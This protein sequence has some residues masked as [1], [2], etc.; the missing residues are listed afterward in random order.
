MAEKGVIG[1]IV[2]LVVIVGGLLAIFGFDSIP[3]LIGDVTN[4]PPS[5]I[6]FTI[7]ISPSYFD[8]GNYDSYD[9]IL[10]SIELIKKSNRNI[11]YLELSKENFKVSRKDEGLN[12]PTSKVNWKDSRSETILSINSHSYYSSSNLKAEGEMNLCQNCFI[13]TDYPYIFTFTIYYK[14]DGGELKSET[15]EEEI[16]IK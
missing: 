13:G 2:A 1:V 8:E 9:E 12:K 11:T 16:P 5:S 7:E 6:P 15:F 4:N 10:F 3:E 14:E